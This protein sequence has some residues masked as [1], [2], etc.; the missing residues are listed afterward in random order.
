MV[1]FSP[2]KQAYVLWRLTASQCQLVLGQSSTEAELNQDCRKRSSCRDVCCIAIGRNLHTVR[3][4]A[5]RMGGNSTMYSL[6]RAGC[7]SFRRS[8]ARGVFLIHAQADQ[9]T[10]R[11]SP[12]RICGP[13]NRVVRG[14]WVRLATQIC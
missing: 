11:C 3:N 4:S 1:K 5:V 13:Q 9:F 10:K 2:L 8:S 7:A 6:N 14:H 12:T